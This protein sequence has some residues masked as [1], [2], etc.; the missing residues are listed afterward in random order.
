[1][2]REDIEKNKGEKKRLVLQKEAS[3]CCVWVFCCLWTSLPQ[4]CPFG[5]HWVSLEKLD[6]SQKLSNQLLLIERQ[7]GK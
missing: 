7:R 2:L 6:T 3:K 1:M 4:F 5:D